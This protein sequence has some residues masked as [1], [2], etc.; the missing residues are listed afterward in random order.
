MR[1]RPL[2][3]RSAVP[4][5]VSGWV[6]RI[7]SPPRAR[8]HHG[9]PKSDCSSPRKGDL[10]MSAYDTPRRPDPPGDH[11]APE[12]EGGLRAP[13]GLSFWGK[14]WWWFHFLILVKLARLRFVAVLV[15]IG[16]VIVKWDT[17]TAYYQRWTR[18]DAEQAAA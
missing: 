5:T 8:P 3:P 11:P 16:L 17:L 1:V 18:P 2:A 12:N 9:E 6:S 7:G 15:L 13:P 4:R 14:A 10:T